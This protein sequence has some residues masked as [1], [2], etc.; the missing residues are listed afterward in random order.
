MYYSSYVFLPIVFMTVVGLRDVRQKWRN[1]SIYG[2]Y[3]HI[4]GQQYCHWFRWPHSVLHVSQGH[5]NMTIYHCT[6]LINRFFC[7]KTV[8]FEEMWE[9]LGQY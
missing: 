7:G 2:Y 5:S 3:P 6:C 9:F 8:F 4:V 1:C